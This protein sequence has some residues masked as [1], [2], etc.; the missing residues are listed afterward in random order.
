MPNGPEKAAE[1]RKM[2]EDCLEVAKRMSL[3]HDRIR[4]MEMAQR[5]ARPCEAS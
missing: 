5:W 2:A 3:D 1:Y 4:M